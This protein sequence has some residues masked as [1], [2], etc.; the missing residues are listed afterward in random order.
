MYSLYTEF[1]RNIYIRME[2]HVRTNFNHFFCK[3]FIFAFRQIFFTKY[4]RN[5]IFIKLPYS[6][7]EIVAKFSVRY[8]YNI[9]HR[10]NHSLPVAD[11]VLQSPYKLHQH[12]SGLKFQTV[13]RPFSRPSDRRYRHQL[14]H[15][16]L[17][18][19]F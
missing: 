14:R 17:L 6:F 3:F 19:R 2:Y 12:F 15:L 7:K 13:R 16:S 4:Y 8:A 9:K 11:L 18:R 10:Y 5:V 1:F